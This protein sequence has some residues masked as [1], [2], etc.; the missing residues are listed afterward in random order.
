MFW[1]DCSI[2]VAM[3]VKY[4]W[5]VYRNYRSR[6]SNA[7]YEMLSTA[8]TTSAEKQKSLES[9]TEVQSS[10]LN[11][12]DIFKLNKGQIC[13]CDILILSSSEHRKTNSSV[14]VDSFTQNGISAVE[15][16][17]TLSLLRNFDY[18]D[19]QLKSYLKRIN[20]KVKYYRCNTE[21][22]RISGT[23]KLSTDPRG[24]SFTNTN[25]ICQGS[26]LCSEFVLGLVL[27]NGRKCIP[28]EKWSTQQLF[29]QSKLSSVH[30]KQ[31]AYA[32]LVAI[33]S[34][35]GCVF[36]KLAAIRFAETI[37]PPAL[38]DIQSFS[39]LTYVCL[40]FS[41]LTLSINT[42]LNLAYWITSVKLQRKYRGIPDSTELAPSSQPQKAPLTTKKRMVLKPKEVSPRSEP[43]FQVFDPTVL[44]QLGDIDDIVF[45]KSGTLVTNRYELASIATKTQLYHAAIEPRFLQDH[46]PI[47]IEDVSDIDPEELFGEVESKAINLDGS[48]QLD[49][50]PMILVN[51]ESRELGI[52]GIETKP[53]EPPKWK[54]DTY[55][56]SIQSDQIP[57]MVKKIPLSQ[58][59]KSSKFI[60]SRTSSAYM[61]EDTLGL[62]AFKAWPSQA[63]EAVGWSLQAIEETAD[64][65]RRPTEGRLSSGIGYKHSLQVDA[66]IGKYLRPSSYSTIKEPRIPQ[67]PPITRKLLLTPVTGKPTGDV[68][69]NCKIEITSLDHQEVISSD[70]GRSQHHQQAVKGPLQFVQEYK[71]KEVSQLMMMF[72]VFN[73]SK[74]VGNR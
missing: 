48:G 59:Y 43:N 15:H 11:V 13:P 62:K 61:R 73:H 64:P 28:A 7:K 56:K 12:G 74:P 21:N 29:S 45:D 19:S 60:S 32:S 4:R 41:C 16:K 14:L 42:T 37:Q 38:L 65:Y 40:Y 63:T 10:S 36:S 6:L 34:L 26:I 53:S 58:V 44:P 55:E 68:A 24:E 3:S 1:I 17:K 57:G 54:D 27:F 47:E 22:S 49:V 5:K 25:I 52:S 31:Q 8:R 20:G 23:F 71:T 33:I 69:G 72:S 51:M 9:I 70:H 35:V 18:H 2:H 39:L 67:S 66:N 46:I 50:K 30:T